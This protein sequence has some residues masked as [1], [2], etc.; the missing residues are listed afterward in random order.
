MLISA[1]SFAQGFTDSIIT[2]YFKTAEFALSVGEKEKLDSFFKKNSSVLVMEVAGHTDTVGNTASNITLSHKRSKAVSD[3]L[4]KYFPNTTYEIK[5]FGEAHPVSPANDALNRR[6]EIT[7]R[8]RS[9]VKDPAAEKEANLI[10]KF[11][12]DNLYFVPDKAILEDFSMDYLNSIIPAL[13]TYKNS[14]FEIRGH[15]NFET[16]LPDSNYMAIMNKLSEDRAKLI[17]NILAANGIPQGQMSYKGMGNTQMV[18]PHPL[19][20]M[21]K[22]KNMRVEILVFKNE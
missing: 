21:E 16:E 14:R 8:T 20:E 5:Y 7:V 6:V 15:V 19:N 17:Y 10:R 3:W 22:R 4:K 12:L 1:G 11:N 18:Y 9:A 2:I 13:K